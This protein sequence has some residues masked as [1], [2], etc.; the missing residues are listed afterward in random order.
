MKTKTNEEYLALFDELQ[1][2]I[3][4]FSDKNRDIYELNGAIF[5]IISTIGNNEFDH[6]LR[7]TGMNEIR[8]DLLDVLKS[9]G[10]IKTKIEKIQKCI[11]VER[12]K[13]NA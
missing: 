12:N 4:E 11:E 10:L 7:K 6:S 2:L 8:Y 1:D 3:S 9:I 5:Q 13:Y